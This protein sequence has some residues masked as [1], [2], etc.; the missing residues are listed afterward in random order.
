MSRLSSVIVLLLLPAL[1][2]GQTITGANSSTIATGQVITITGSSFGTRSSQTPFKYDDGEDRTHNESVTAGGWEIRAG[3]GNSTD[4]AYL[5]DYSN[6]L[7][8]TGSTMSLRT[9]WAQ[10][11][12]GAYDRAFGKTNTSDT[13][14]NM[15]V[16]CWVFVSDYTP[17]IPRQNKMIRSVNHLGGNGQYPNFYPGWTCW[18]GRPLQFH[19][20]PSSIWSNIDYQTG[21]DN[22]FGQWVHLQYWW[23]LNTADTYDGVVKAWF[24]GTLKADRSNVGLRTSASPGNLTQTWFGMFISKSEEWPLGVPGGCENIFQG[25]I[26]IFWDN[27]YLDVERS[28]VEIG[29]VATYNSCTH[30][31]IQPMTA[32]ADGAISFTANTGSFAQNDEVY[33]FVVDGDGNISA[34]YGPL[35]VS[36]DTPPADT[37]PPAA[38]T[39]LT[40][41]GGVEQI[42]LTWNANGEGDLAGYIVSR[43]TTTGAPYTE[44]PGTITGTSYTDT[45]VSV[46][47]TYYYAIQAVDTSLNRSEYS[48]ED[49]AAPSGGTVTIKNPYNINATAIGE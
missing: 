35:T 1:A 24:N 11:D 16:D 4:S 21:F 28:R 47:T 12:V 41:T 8:R 27:V 39:G 10:N 26:E 37:T 45:A 2:F 49:S 9:F 30:R 6:L 38:P 23:E 48:T 40:A 34:G 25:T 17:E 5:P 42:A 13:F 20:E 14:N 18:S 46:G 22:Y 32:W 44:I 15:Y 7:T 33:L 43:S 31:E 29:N 19:G 3:G 36:T